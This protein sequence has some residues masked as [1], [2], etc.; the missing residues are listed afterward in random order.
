MVSGWGSGMGCLS[1]NVHWLDQG[2]R[3]LVPLRLLSFASFSSETI[4]RKVKSYKRKRETCR[5]VRLSF[6]TS[7][8]HGWVNLLNWFQ[9]FWNHWALTSESASLFFLLFF[10]VVI[11]PSVLPF[12]SV[13]PLVWLFT[14]SAASLSFFF[15]FFGAG[16][17]QSGSCSSSWSSNCFFFSFLASLFFFWAFLREMKLVGYKR[18]A[19]GLVSLLTAYLALWHINSQSNHRNKLHDKQTANI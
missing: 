6:V 10:C 14:W 7:Q 5:I 18:W 17:S 12:M 19:I 9:W 8:P 4:K 1:W 11:T 3:W 16:G 2:C 15:F 13:A